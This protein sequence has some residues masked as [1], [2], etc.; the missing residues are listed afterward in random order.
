MWVR[1]SV[2][3]GV[4]VFVAQPEVSRKV[5]HLRRELL[6]LRSERATDLV[7]QPEK[8]HVD[9]LRRLFERNLLEGH[10]GV[11]EIQVHGLQ[12]FV[13]VVDATHSGEGHSRVAQQQTDQLRTAVA[14]AANDGCTKGCG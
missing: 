4:D 13:D 14:G 9:I 7:R 1:L 11:E 5:D 2:E 8:D 6:E 3:L 12:R 10:A